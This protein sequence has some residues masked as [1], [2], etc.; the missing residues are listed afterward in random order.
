[1]DDPVIYPPPP[2]DR[3]DADRDGRTEKRFLT[4]GEAAEYLNDLG[5]PVSKLTL[6]KWATT[7][8]GPAFRKFGVRAL[9]EPRELVQWAE[10]KLSSPIRST[11]DAA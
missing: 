6:M 2:H 11:S 10:A 4:R 5:F 3:S 9:Y 8:G 1:M 7:G